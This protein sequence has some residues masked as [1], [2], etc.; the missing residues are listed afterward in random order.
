MPKSGSRSQ[1]HS[2]EVYA[3][4]ERLMRGGS[5]SFFAASRLLPARYRCAATAIYAFCRVADD[6]VDEMPPGASIDVVMA[7]LHERLEA[8]YRQE[9]FGIDADI[10]FSAIAHAYNIPSALPLALLDGFQWDASGRR[11][12]TIDE[13]YD[14]AARVAG[15]VGAMMT[16]VMGGRSRQT[17][18]RACELGVA[19][20][21]TNIARDVGEDARRGRIYLPLQWMRDVGVHPDEFLSNPE[22][23]PA[24]ASV[25]QRLLKV[26]DQLYTRAETGIAALPRDARAS[27]MAA[28]LIY[29]DIGRKLARHRF[30]SINHRSVVSKSRKLVLIAR[31]ISTYLLAPQK[32]YLLTPLPAIEFL[33]QA[34]PPGEPD[35]SSPSLFA[36]V[37]G[38]LE[39]TGSQTRAQQR[40]RSRRSF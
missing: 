27:I 16:L 24:L 28:R 40:A 17:V 22:F 39:R 19:M 31:A 8:I 10:A 14:Y 3:T 30:D 9:P 20:Q 6:A 26:A 34:V 29:A 37:V 36:S 18:A 15:T 7:Y 5:H 11:Y 25:T 32:D 23:T 35:R 13:L 2:P 33:V 4:C 21:L 38:I 12:E 1:F